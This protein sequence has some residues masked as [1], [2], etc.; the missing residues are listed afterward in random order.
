MPLLSLN[1]AFLLEGKAVGSSHKN[2]AWRLRFQNVWKGNLRRFCFQARTARKLTAAASPGSGISLFGNPWIEEG[3]VPMSF[4]RRCLLGSF[5]MLAALANCG[6]HTLGEN[7]PPSCCPLFFVVFPME[8][9]V[10]RDPKRFAFMPSKV[11][12]DICS[13]PQ[14]LHHRNR[15]ATF[16]RFRSGRGGSIPCG[17]TQLRSAHREA[18]EVSVPSKKRPWKN[19]G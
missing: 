7:S 1:C 12:V 19:A 4:I 2:S 13:V 9:V 15:C 5:V 14:L 16:Q 11:P 6:V 17:I 8:R 3:P 18:R 10:S